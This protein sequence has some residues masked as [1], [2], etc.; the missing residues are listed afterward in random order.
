MRRKHVL[1][2]IIPILGTEHPREDTEHTRTHAREQAYAHNPTYAHA[3][4]RTRTH[5]HAR[6]HTH[7]HE[8]ARTGDIR[9]LF[10][11]CFVVVYIVQLDQSQN[12]EPHG[13]FPPN[14]RT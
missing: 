1:L 13:E 3:S 5:E 11:F 7:A 14:H 4:T 8:H 12:V 10:L 9:F 6:A 2:Q